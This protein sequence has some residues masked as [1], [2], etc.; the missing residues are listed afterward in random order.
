MK[1]WKRALGLGV[2]MW[3]VPFVVAFLVFP[4]HESA[5]PLFESVMAVA[6]AGSAAGLGYLYV[7]SGASTA[8]GLRLGLIWFVLC[9][10]IDAPLML[11]GGPMQMTVADYMADIGLTYLAIPVVTTGLAAAFAAGSGSV[12]VRDEEA[13]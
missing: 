4:F 10:L 1:S 8:E 2:L 11:L 3:L 5:R 12:A 9:V 7:R 13:R 6:V